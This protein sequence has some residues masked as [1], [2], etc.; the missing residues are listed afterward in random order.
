MSGDS[1]SPVLAGIDGSRDG[2]IALSWTVSYATGGFAE[3]VL[4]RPVAVIH[5]S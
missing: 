1:Q 4:G 2:L 3:L 5:H